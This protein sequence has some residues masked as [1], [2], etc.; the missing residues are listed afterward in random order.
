MYRTFETEIFMNI[1]S[2]FTGTMQ[3]PELI[4]VVSLQN[5]ALMLSKATHPRHCTQAT[6]L[7]GPHSPKDTILFFQ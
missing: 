2:K 1:Q 3:Q 6:A 4:P 5:L 7:A